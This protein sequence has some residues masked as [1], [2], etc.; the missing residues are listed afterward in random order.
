MQGDREVVVPL[1]DGPG[2]ARE[3]LVVAEGWEVENVGD[4][5]GLAE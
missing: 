5:P 4:V 2:D 3:L 1:V